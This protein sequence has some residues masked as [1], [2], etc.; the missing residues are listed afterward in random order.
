MKQHQRL[1]IPQLEVDLFGEAMLAILLKE[2]CTV[3]QSI[4]IPVFLNY[5]AHL[6]HSLVVIFLLVDLDGFLVVL[7]ADV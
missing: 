5:S 6:N 1:V 2:G 3:F 4:L 7:A